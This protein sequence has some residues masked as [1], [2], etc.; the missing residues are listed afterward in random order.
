MSRINPKAVPLTCDQ[1]EYW[2]RHLRWSAAGELVDLDG[3]TARMQIRPTKNSTTVLHTL[4]TENGG[5]SLDVQEIRDRE[6]NIHLTI[7][8]AATET[9]VPKTYHY[10]LQMVSPDDRP[11]RLVGGTFVVD[12]EVTR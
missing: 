6:Y 2:V 7:P 11:K 5:I 1:G 3:W 9:F 10:D 8:D 12:G 4:T